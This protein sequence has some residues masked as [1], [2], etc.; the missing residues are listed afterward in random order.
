MKTTTDQ[1][2]PA[3]KTTSADKKGGL[4]TSLKKIRIKGPVDFSRS[5]GSYTYTEESLFS[6]IHGIREEIRTTFGTGESSLKTIRED[7]KR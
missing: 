4:L 5:V 3:K 6:Q 7:R 1:S 2:A